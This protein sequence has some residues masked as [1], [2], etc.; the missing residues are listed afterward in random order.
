MS[1]DRQVAAARS[2]QVDV[3]AFWRTLGSRATGLTVVT[4]DSDEGPAGFLGLSATHLTADPPTILV[5]ID[6]RTSALAG[7]LSRRHFAVNYLPVGAKAVGEAFGDKAVTGA[8]RFALGSWSVLVTGAPVLTDALGVFDC[9]VEEIIE[10]DDITIV[11][12]AAVAAAVNDGEP[13]I[14]FRGKTYEG[15]P[16]T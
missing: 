11:I 4:T 14:Y 16:P 2:G 10:R 13:L 3:K 5:S 9:V 1:D 6:K 15:L 7:V 12:G 8:A